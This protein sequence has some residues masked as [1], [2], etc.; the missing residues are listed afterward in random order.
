MDRNIFFHVDFTLDPS[1]YTNLLHNLN[2]MV[3]HLVY[4]PRFHHLRVPDSHLDILSALGNIYRI[5]SRCSISTFIVN[6]LRHGRI[7]LPLTAPVSTF[8]AVTLHTMFLKKVFDEVMLKCNE[9]FTTIKTT[10]IGNKKSSRLGQITHGPK[11]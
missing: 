10:I 8:I 5:P 2:R 1:I 7:Y 11:N 9:V 3:H 4:I 6:Y